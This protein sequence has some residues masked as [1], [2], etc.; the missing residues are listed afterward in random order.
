MRSFTK[1]EKKLK[2]KES[3]PQEDLKE[4]KMMHIKAIIDNPAAI[5]HDKFEVEEEE[6]EVV[7][8]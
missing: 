7:I 2:R 8:S 5:F 6:S 4:R 3:L 1:A